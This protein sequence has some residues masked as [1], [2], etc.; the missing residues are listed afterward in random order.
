MAPTLG[1]GSYEGYEDVHSIFPAGSASH[2]SRAVVFDFSP[3]WGHSNRKAGGGKVSEVSLQ[4]AVVRGK[5][6]GL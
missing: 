4:V 1:S 6:Q 2:G 5:M 3:A